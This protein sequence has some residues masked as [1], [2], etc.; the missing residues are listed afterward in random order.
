MKLKG[1]VTSGTQKGTYFMSQKI[2]SKQFKDKLGF[3]PF[4]GTL[5]ILI[6]EKD[7][8]KIDEI[9]K[10]DMELL[11]GSEGFGDVLFIKAKLQEFIDGAIIFPEKSKHPEEYLE[12]VAEEN[13]RE[14]LNLRDGDEVILTI[15]S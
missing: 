5:N 13:L 14:K 3:K 12:F 9:K 6:K 15:Q 11:K 8:E 4:K 1:M 7:L 2:Y 10:K